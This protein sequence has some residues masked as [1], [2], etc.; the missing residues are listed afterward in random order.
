MASETLYEIAVQY[1]ELSDLVDREE[2]T[3]EEVADTFAAIKD[4][5]GVKIDAIVKIYREK[6]AEE[7]KFRDEAK[8]LADKAAR[9]ARAATRLKGLAAMYLRMTQQQS[10]RG[11]MFSVRLKSNRPSVVVVDEAQIPDA[12]LKHETS[13]NKAAIQAAIKA[14]EDVPGVWLAPSES[15]VFY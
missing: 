1:Q 15:V 14:G 12:Y 7:K 9:N 10:A 11:E 4:A 13:V 8:H 5:A 2:V 6:V 3:A